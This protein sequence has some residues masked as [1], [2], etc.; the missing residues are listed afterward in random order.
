MTLYRYIPNCIRFGV[1]KNVSEELKKYS[2]YSVIE[3]KI[4]KMKSDQLKEKE[5]HPYSTGT[6]A[7]PNY[8]QIRKKLEKDLL[9]DK[10]IVFCTLSAS[11][12]KCFS[13]LRSVF[14]TVIIDEAAQAVEL[15]TLIPLKYNCDRCVLV[16]DPQ[17]LPATV[18]SKVCG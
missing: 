4:Q 11:G 5:R 7:R 16:G 14:N 2:L 8:K 18:L 10:S 6:S 9:E 3:E 17:Q 15:S 13:S 1:E 12:A